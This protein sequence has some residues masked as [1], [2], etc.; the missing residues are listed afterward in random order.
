MKI[1]IVF[2]TRTGITRKAAED[3]AELLKKHVDNVQMEELIDHKDRSGKI[4]YLAAAKDAMRKN[5]TEIDEIKHHPKDFDMIILGTPVWAGT[6]A[7][8]LRT[9]LNSYRKDMH[10][11]SFY[12]T[13]GGGGASKTFKGIKSILDLSPKAT[14]S[15][16]DKDVKEGKHSSELQEFIKTIIR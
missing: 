11:V 5:E 1:L 10:D 9:Y 14:L 12:C 16:R 3:M 6:M 7:P 4:G 2:Y 8:A 15:L 13:H